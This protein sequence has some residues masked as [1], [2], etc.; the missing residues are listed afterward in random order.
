[1]QGNRES[2]VKTFPTYRICTK[3]REIGNSGRRLSLGLERALN[4]G[5]VGRRLSLRSGS[6]LNVG[7]QAKQGGDFP[8][9]TDLN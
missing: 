2:N 6:G 9:D 7:I 5:N 3:C 8:Y 1:M 4:G